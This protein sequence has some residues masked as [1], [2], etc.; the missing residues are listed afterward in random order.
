MGGWTFDGLQPP[1]GGKCRIGGILVQLVDGFGL[2]GVKS[3]KPAAKGRAILVAAFTDGRAELRQLLRQRAVRHAGVLEREGV[4]ERLA[5][6]KR[7]ANPAPPVNGDEFRIIGFKRG[8]KPLLFPC[9]AYHDALQFLKCF[10]GMLANTR[11]FVKTI[12]RI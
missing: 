3:V 11:D 9:P 1:F 2:D 8:Q 6:Q 12:L 7:L 10:D 5:N 4:A